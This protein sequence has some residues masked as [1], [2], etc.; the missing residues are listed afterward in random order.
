MEPLANEKTTPTSTTPTT[1]TIHSHYFLWSL[2]SCLDAMITSS[3]TLLSNALLTAAGL[4]NIKDTL[5]HFLLLVYATI[6]TLIASLQRKTKH[7]QYIQCKEYNE[8]LMVHSYIKE[9]KEKFLCESSKLQ[10]ISN[11]IV[12]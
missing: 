4:S 2:H 11:T 9:L 5:N 12:P 10:D 7:S 6:Y 3:L 8:V 1:M